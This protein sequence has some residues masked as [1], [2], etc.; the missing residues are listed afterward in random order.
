MAVDPGRVVFGHPKDAL[1]LNGRLP[2]PSRSWQLKCHQHGRL[3]R[4]LCFR[5]L[6]SSH[7]VCG[8]R[9]LN[10]LNELIVLDGL[11]SPRLSS[12]AIPPS[13]SRAPA[14]SP[15]AASRR[16]LWPIGRI[17]WRRRKRVGSAKGVSWRMSRMRPGGKWPGWREYLD[18]VRASRRNMWPGRM[19]CWP[20]DLPSV[21][22]LRMSA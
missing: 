6:R 16:L 20:R 4:G 7:R 22:Q 9:L 11:F 10:W 12:L 19:L 21:R 1:P 3:P 17:C 18:G 2:S 14:A 5:V 13:P 8:L 15:A